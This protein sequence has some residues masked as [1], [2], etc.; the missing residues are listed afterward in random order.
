MRL[1]VIASAALFTLVAARPSRYI[2]QSTKGSDLLAQQALTHLLTAAKDGSLNQL[3]ATKGVS[4]RCS[5]RDVVVRKEYA[6]LSNKEKLDYTRAGEIS[7]K[8]W[9]SSYYKSGR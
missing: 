4:Q 1:L 7:L 3:L 9:L 8:K 2:P 6:D 5:A